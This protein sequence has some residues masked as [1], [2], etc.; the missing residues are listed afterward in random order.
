VKE[1]ASRLWDDIV[2]GVDPTQCRRCT[3]C[4]PL[5]A[6]PAWAFRRAGQNDVPFAS[7]DLCLGCYACADACPHR[8]V[9]PPRIG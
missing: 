1:R 8:A 5:A 7:R 3:E 2:P 9:L 4:P 6:C